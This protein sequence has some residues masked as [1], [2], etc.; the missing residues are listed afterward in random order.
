[1]S[2]GT[3]GIAAVAVSGEPERIDEATPVLLHR[4]LIPGTDVSALSR[5]GQ[6]RWHINEG[7]FEEDAAAYSF[8][9]AA[10]PDPL[11][12]FAKLYFW[13]VIN[14]DSP[15]PLRRTATERPSLRTVAN[16]WVPF[17]AFM[18]WL[19]HRGIT[20]MSQ[21]TA[22]LLDD[23][24]IDVG[25]C[26][27]ALGLKYRRIVE[28]RRLWSYRLLLPEDMRLPTMPPW[29]G[30]S[31]RVLLGAVRAKRE[32]LTPRITEDTMRA[33]L[34]WSLRFV[35]DFADDILA[36]H[37]EYLYLHFRG[38]QPGRGVVT[39]APD[40]QVHQRVALYIDR[41]RR[42]NGSL[43][44][45]LVANGEVRIDWRHLTKVLDY[46]SESSLASGRAGQLLLDSGLP[47]AEDA[48]LDTPITARID[49]APWHHGP[50]PNN[51][52][53]HL[54]RHL[55][56]ACLVVIAYLSGA[57][58]GEVLNLRRGCIE[59]DAINDMWLMTGVFFKNA[60]DVNG[61]K[62]PAG[63]Q[64]RDPWVVV[65][66]VA[67]AVA[68][69]ERLHD[70][71]LLFPSIIEAHRQR[72]NTRRKGNARIPARCADDLAA[73]VEWVNTR[74]AHRAALAIPLDF[75]GPLN[76]TRFRRTLAWFI[77]RRPRGL[78]AGSIQY[79]HVH[80]RLLQGYAGG[81]DAGFIDE[82]AFEDFLARL[83]QLAED[84]KALRA[85]ET[86]SG[87]AAQTYRHRVAAATRQFAGHVLTSNRQARD[88]LTNPA[89]QI[90]HGDAMTCVF[91]ATVAAC[92]LRGTA[93]DPLVTPQIDD[94]RPWCR[95]IART[96][97]DITA[98]RTRRDRL[99]LI[100]DDTL[101][102]PIRCERDQAEL[103]RI[104]TILETHDDANR[105]GP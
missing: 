42:E 32:N 78:V 3:G 44:G 20:T 10:I 13:Q 49:D 51:R 62:L 93:E 24:L 11:R 1:M 29:G 19:H 6:D 58:P 53:R 99:T 77:R 8:N 81:Y 41:L 101:A 38:R 18:D 50:I 70:H 43:P 86:V 100:V 63:L 15:S 79:G 7:I 83:E 71:Q 39:R 91:D 84:E 98:L 82:L 105:P 87:P 25:N 12:G 85:G 75:Q 46:T 4:E 89:L 2:L 76:I 30:D 36:A 80:T 74:C 92:Q 55:S 40:G 95:N 5:F 54:A 9:F 21:V 67:D 16:M 45:K 60:V 104:T 57:R 72:T 34:W 35:E 64:R 102:P 14:R 31:A 94:C 65:K 69:L 103:R 90:Y 56:T 66:P 22:E 59:H 37:T 73:F 26:D 68:V 97:R 96:D 48:F 33:L 27:I 88:L 52:A 28:I 61:N 23:Y 47:I 17:R